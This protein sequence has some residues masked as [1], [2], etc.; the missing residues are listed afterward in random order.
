MDPYLPASR[1]AAFTRAG[2]IEKAKKLLLAIDDACACLD[3]TP[4]CGSAGVDYV[5]NLSAVAMV[6]LRWK[7]KLDRPPSSETFAELFRLI[8]ER[9]PAA[10]GEGRGQ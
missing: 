6:N 2:Q 8:K 4:P 1:Q 3:I 7:A 10:M 5:G 9:E